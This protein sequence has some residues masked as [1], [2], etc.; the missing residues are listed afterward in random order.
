MDE[1]DKINEAKQQINAEAVQKVQN[2]NAV[3]DLIAVNQSQAQKGTIFE[4][5][6]V[7]FK[8]ILA[9][10]EVQDKKIAEMNQVIASTIGAFTQLIA[11][12]AN[13]P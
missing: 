6:K 12:A 5:H 8:T 10:H 2:F 11:S 4:K 3:E 9:Q 13:D 7:E 1:L